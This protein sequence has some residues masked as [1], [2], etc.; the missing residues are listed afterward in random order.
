MANLLGAN[1]GANYKGFLNLGN[2]INTPLNGATALQIT[3]G[4]GNGSPLTLSLTKVGIGTPTPS[5]KLEVTDT[6]S[7][8]QIKIDGGGA[9]QEGLLCASGGYLAS[10]NPASYDYQFGPLQMNPAF[11][12]INFAGQGILF[13]NVTAG[14]I[15]IKN[16]TGCGNSAITQT[17][18][19]VGV[20]GVAF[21]VGTT[22]PDA[23]AAL[24]VVSTTQGILFPRMT[25]T[26]KN[27]IV[28]P[29]AGLVIYDTT[30]GKLCVRTASGWQT[31]TS[32]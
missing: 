28:S 10:Y 32:A 25:T 26:Q 19:C 11:Y 23:T 9:L 1:I 21:G 15:P 5:A 24:E 3:D 27:A 12:S 29:A 31:I 18:N 20:T 2:T 6:S 16:N 30:L 22:T 17:Y 13:G 7:A 8:P 14:T 4:M